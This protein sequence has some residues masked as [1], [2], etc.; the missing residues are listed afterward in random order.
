MKKSKCLIGR[1]KMYVS[2]VSRSVDS[3]KISKFG[4]S[5]S[6]RTAQRE[7]RQTKIKQNLRVVSTLKANFGFQKNSVQT[8]LTALYIQPNQTKFWPEI[9]FNKIYL[10]V[11]F[12]INRTK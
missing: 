8:P 10:L 2:I 7:M 3:S 12:R 6:L 9:H 5:A 4:E 11:K 1:P